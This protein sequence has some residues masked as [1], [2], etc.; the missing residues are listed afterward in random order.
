MKNKQ[1]AFLGLWLIGGVVPYL[2][3]NASLPIYYY[4]I[5]ASVAIIILAAYI[6]VRL[7]WVGIGL[8]M[9]AIASNLVLINKYNPKGTI[10]EITVQTDMLLTDETKVMDYMYK[11]AKGEQFSVNA[12][13]IPYKIN[14]TWA[15][16]FEWYGKKKYGYMPVWGG[17][18]AWGYPG[19]LTIETNRSKL[20]DARFTI[21]EPKR[22]MDQKWIDEYLKEENIFSKIV[23][24]ENIG[25]FTIESRVKR[26]K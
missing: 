23:K 21:V 3:D 14:T 22:G 4:T 5:G 25:R 9:L 16:L 20:P 6:M 26:T 18:A 15:Y 10:A 12:V 1:L 11:E 2:F 13:T 19:N 7:R 17:E 8:L 24:I